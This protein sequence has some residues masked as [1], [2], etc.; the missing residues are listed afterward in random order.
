MKRVAGPLALVLVVCLIGASEVQG[1]FGGGLTGKT[2]APSLITTIVADLT[3]G[4]GTDGKGLTAIRVQKSA[5]SAA[6]LFTSTVIQS[7]V[8]DCQRILQERANGF[9][10]FQGLISNWVTPFSVRAAL[11]GQFG[12]PDKAAISDTSDASCT[13]VDREDGTGFRQIL[14]LT[15]V[16]QFQE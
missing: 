11:V 4:V 16:M 12:D 8:V 7:S 1:A 9:D 15:A 14:S 5:L 3:G 2:K 6:V 10:R 13:T